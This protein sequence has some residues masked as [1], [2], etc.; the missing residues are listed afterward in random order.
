MGR[1]SF[2]EIRAA[3][4]KLAV[5][6]TPG[7]QALCTHGSVPWEM[8]RTLARIVISSSSVNSSMKLTRA[9][10]ERVIGGM[11]HTLST[12]DGSAKESTHTHEITPQFVY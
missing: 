6:S 7:K 5:L 3:R 10:A 12:F 2:V 4:H 8:N 11:G 1:D 9:R